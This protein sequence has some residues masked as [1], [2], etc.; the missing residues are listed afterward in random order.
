VNLHYLFIS[1]EYWDG[2]TV[3]DSKLHR[4][5]FPFLQCNIISIMLTG[6]VFTLGFH[7][8]LEFDILIHEF[9]PSSWAGNVKA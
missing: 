6:S 1:D 9:L 8:E 2:K 7:L 4:D 3:T 5:G